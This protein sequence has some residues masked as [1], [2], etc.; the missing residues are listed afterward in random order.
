MFSGAVVVRGGMSGASLRVGAAGI[1]FLE[2]TRGRWDLS[3]VLWGRALRL[4]N[5]WQ[6]AWVCGPHPS[7]PPHVLWETPFHKGD[8]T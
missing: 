5:I 1:G 4:T 3:V 2:T 7:G 8:P 6:L